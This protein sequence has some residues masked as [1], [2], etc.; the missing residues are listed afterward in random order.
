MVFINLP[1]SLHSVEVPVTHLYIKTIDEKYTYVPKFP[2]GRLMFD[3]STEFCLLVMLKRISEEKINV[4]AYLELLPEIDL[5][6]DLKFEITCY[7]NDEKI[8]HKKTS[9]ILGTVPENNTMGFQSMALISVEQYTLNL[10]IKFEVSIISHKNITTLS[11]L[12]ESSELQTQI[13]S[14]LQTY[15][16]FEFFSKLRG[17]D[18]SVCLETIKSMDD[19]SYRKCSNFHLFHKKCLVDKISGCPLCRDELKFIF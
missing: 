19:V 14:K 18:C 17:A 10:N 7:M 4:S 6:K 11:S 13:F 12:R 8:D 2:E 15:E 9:T 1:P 16:I 5:I 3:D